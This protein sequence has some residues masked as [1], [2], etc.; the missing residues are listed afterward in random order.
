ME[1]LSWELWNGKHP[2]GSDPMQRRSSSSH[3]F[4]RMVGGKGGFF[5]LIY[6]AARPALEH[7]TQ[8][9]RLVAVVAPNSLSHTKG[10]CLLWLLK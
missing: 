5:R 2:P 3:E 4:P 1:R 10:T 9:E 8:S 6:P 7:V